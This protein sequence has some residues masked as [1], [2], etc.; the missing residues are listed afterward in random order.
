MTDR[1]RNAA[2]REQVRKAERDE[3]LQRRQ[4]LADLQTVLGIVQGRRLLYRWITRL[5]PMA[6]LWEPSG[7]LQYKVGFHDVAVML[8]NEITEADPLAWVLM[9]K[10][11]L[12][13]T[14]VRETKNDAEEKEEE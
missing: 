13:R 11:A 8:L 1:V 5:R 14:T 7:L 10:E 2:D 3:Q 9:Q 4:D 6:N 12:E